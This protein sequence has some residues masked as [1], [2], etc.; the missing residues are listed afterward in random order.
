MKRKDSSVGSMAIAAGIVAS[1]VLWVVF[2][3]GKPPVPVPAY[4]V[5][6]VIDGDTFV[7]TENQYIRIA[8]IEAPEIDLCGGPEAKK[9]LEEMI[10]QKPLYMKVLFRDAFDRL[11][12][13]VY[14]GN[15]YVNEALI[16]KGYAY[17]LP[18]GSADTMTE[19]K[20][21]GETAREKEVG[22]FS[23]SCTQQTNS[24]NPSCNIKGNVR[25][26]NIYYTS[27]CGMYHNTIVQLYMGDRWFCTEVEAIASGF[28]KPKQCE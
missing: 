11:V 9:A 10:L 15:N 14:V 13:Q 25:N 2:G 8:S 26:G 7:T 12:S 22:I 5:S 1:S 17:Y 28:R 3:K 20:K 18:R 27:E 24:V 23:N 21:A 6:R 16:Q 4:Q 19:L